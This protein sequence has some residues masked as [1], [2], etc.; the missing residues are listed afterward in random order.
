[1]AKIMVAAKGG[2]GDVLPLLAVLS[3]LQDRGHE[4]L[5]AGDRHFAILARDSEV[6]FYALEGPS[7]PFASPSD[8]ALTML[9][10]LITTVDLLLVNPL[11]PAAILLAQKEGVPWVYS[12]ASPL[13][14][15]SPAD[16]P[17]WPVLASLQR[18]L[19][20]QSWQRL[21][22]KLARASAYKR[23]ANVR[24]LAR[25][26]Q[27]QVSGHPCFEG[28]YSP[29]LNLLLASPHLVS[30]DS[31]PAKVVLT[32]F[33]PQLPSSLQNAPAVQRL[34]EFLSAG[35]A[36]IVVA[37]GGADRFDPRRF[38]AATQQACPE[39]GLRA[40][41]SL[42]PCYH[43]QISAQES[44]LA[45]PYLP[46]SVL[47]AGARAIIHS[48]GIGAL[49]W[50]LRLGKPSLLLPSVWD[51]FDNTRRALERG[52]G[53]WPQRNP[54]AIA[55]GLQTILADSWQRLAEH[56]P[57][58]ATEDGAIVAAD[59]I[60]T[61]LGQLSTSARCLPVGDGDVSITHKFAQ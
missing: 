41:F 51:Q 1:M 9:H 5:L 42:R 43:A 4:M 16:P 61:L 57:E 59:A 24:T 48:G 52:L 12:S 33:C 22:M 32:G 26:L 27:T 25:R 15:A 19:P 17:W 6:P 40:I 53:V 47:F 14:F 28:L 31:L 39:L 13:A 30:S 8:E 29:W 18:H 7:A 35:P 3:T 56:S 20:S 49:S 23:F 45:L 36:P 34:G 2:F 21:A 11:V 60:E 54:Q 37:P 50:A 46:Y 58:V 44:F 10:S 55:R 38:V